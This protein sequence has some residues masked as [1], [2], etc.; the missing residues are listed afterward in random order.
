MPDEKFL[1]YRAK[2]LAVNT[3]D[4]P[5]RLTQ[6]ITVPTFR[7]YQAGDV[8]PAGTLLRDIINKE[9]NSVP[10]SPKVTI[11]VTGDGTTVPAAGEHNV[12]YGN[13]FTISSAIPGSGKQLKSAT[14]DGVNITLPYTERNVIADHTIRVE[15]EDIPAHT[16]TA[17][18]GANGS[19]TPSGAVSVADGANQTFTI[20]PENGYQIKDVKVDGASVGNVPSYT[21][22]NVTADHTIAAEFEEIPAVTHTIVATAGTGGSITPSGNVTVGDG[23]SQSFTITPESGY[24]IKDVKVDGASVGAVATYPFTNVTADHT[25]EAE[26]EVIPI[27]THKITASAG[28]GGSISPNGEVIVGDHGS[29][30][31]TITPD[32]ASGYIIDDVFV[33]G[34]S[35]GKVSTYTFSDVTGDHTISAEFVIPVVTSYFVTPAAGANGSI[36]PSEIQTFAENDQVDLTFTAS[37]ASGY[38]VDTW[39][40]TGGKTDTQTGGT[41]YHLE[42]AAITANI[43]VGVTF[44]PVAVE[45]YHVVIADA[46]DPS[47]TSA[48]TISPTVGTH[49]VNVGSSQAV[50]ATP[51]SGFKIKSFKVDS[52]EQAISD[53]TQAFTY[54]VSGIAADATVNIIVEFERIPTGNIYANAYA[55]VGRTYKEPTESIMVLG[56]PVA[57]PAAAMAQIVAGTYE[58]T[59]KQQARS[60][61]TFVMAKS[62]GRL[63]SIKQKGMEDE[64]LGDVFL[65]KTMT[66]D[67]VDYWCYHGTSAGSGGIEYILGGHE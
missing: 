39:T 12:V 67:G 14:F 10:P 35:V 59:S 32:T 20:A 21:F 31:F 11:V 15:F 50:V 30:T 22:S 18:A 1:K 51:N 60:C 24:Q 9:F 28:V 56:E 48:G 57:D 26:F 44:K 47:L 27:V 13:D 23:S 40:I 2:I 34:V 36:T 5:D 25:I 65:E 37:P 62:L 16:I 6:N 66:F 7:G 63:T 33:D 4:Q 64:Y 53:P 58:W 46:T 55:N 43:N 29:Q 38:E 41:T 19:I 61:E 49:D 54:T 42:V 3:G 8:I 45:V 17:T 52:T